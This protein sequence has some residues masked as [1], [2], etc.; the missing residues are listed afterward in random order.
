MPLQGPLAGAFQAHLLAANP[1]T[2]TGF[3]AWVLHPGMLFGAREQWW[4]RPGAR[5]TPHE[6][7]DLG[8][9]EDAAGRLHWVPETLAVPAPLA[10]RVVRLAPDFL[11]TS[12]FL[13]HEGWSEPGRFYTA[14]GHTRPRPSLRVGDQ[15]AAGEVLARLAASRGRAPAHLHLTFAWLP[16]EASLDALDWRTLGRDPAVRLLDPLPC[17]S[18]PWR[19]TPALPLPDP[20]G[21]RVP[22]RER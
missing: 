5:A 9:Y 18:L 21:R 16:P 8:C 10:G 17:L 19:L 4:G 13:A 3:A 7:L 14:L 2:L 1:D 22:S 11:G 12:I 15:V 20:A 6:G